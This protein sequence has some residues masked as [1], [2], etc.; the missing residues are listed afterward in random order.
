M[1]Y[2][3][4]ALSPGDMC[5][6]LGTRL[7]KLRLSRNITQAALAQESGVGLRTL[8][9]LEAGGS[10]TLDSFLRIAIRLDLADSLL[11]A[12]PSHDIRPVERIGA[13]GSERKRARPIS[14][15]AAEKSWTWETPPGD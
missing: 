13:R 3:F 7:A 10:C 6:E 14:G 11:G 8:R 12:V 1:T 5:A 4:N 15:E 9:R 2:N